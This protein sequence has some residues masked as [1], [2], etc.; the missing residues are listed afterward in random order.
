MDAITS[1]VASGN[2]SAPGSWNPAQVPMEG[3]TVCR[4]RSGQI[5]FD[6]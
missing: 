2:W 6:G 1:D 3:D 4:E 5:E